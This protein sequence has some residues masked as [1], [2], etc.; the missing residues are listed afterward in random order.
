MRPLDLGAR[1]HDVVF[2]NPAGAPVADGDSSFTQL[3]APLA[4]IWWVA[5]AAASARDLERVA[6]GTVLSANT[7][8]VTGAYL[9]GVTIAS[10][11]R[12]TDRGGQAH[13]ASVVGVVDVED[14][15]VDMELACV[16]LVDVPPAA[17]T[18]WM[19]QRWTQ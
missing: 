13:L 11:M 18:S 8:L 3:Y 17:D 12:W 2:E 9:P 6:A 4:P 7:R 19:Q 15:G 5:M 10:R 16:E 1:V 14:R